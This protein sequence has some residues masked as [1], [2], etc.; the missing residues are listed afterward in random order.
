MQM[1]MLDNVKALMDRLEAD[2]WPSSGIELDDGTTTN[3]ALFGEV[4]KLS[5]GAHS[6]A[7][8]LAGTAMPILR[9]VLLL[10][11]AVL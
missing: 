6:M 11:A 1:A 4:V 8:L 9:V 3:I 5:G 7:G 2:G 10:I